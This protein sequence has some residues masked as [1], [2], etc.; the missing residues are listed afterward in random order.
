M[1]PH[2][3][4]SRYVRGCRCEPCGAA[5][6][7]YARQRDRRHA[8]VRDAV[9]AGEDLDQLVAHLEARAER[10]TDPA[11]ADEIMRLLQ[12]VESVRRGRGGVVF[13]R[14]PGRTTP[15][16]RE[17]LDE[18]AFLLESGTGTGEAVTR[19]GWRTAEAALR[20]A[21]REQHRAAFLLQAVA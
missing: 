3:T 17:R 11:R 2:G 16:A 21:H 18:L 4:R 8:R 10:T 7:E 13:E 6:R 1:S 9:A 5:N 12:V 15:T 14:G 20:A 19:C